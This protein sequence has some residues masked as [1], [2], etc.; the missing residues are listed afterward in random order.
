MSPPSAPHFS[1]LLKEC[2]DLLVR[3]PG[4][5]YL[6]ATIGPAGHSS[7]LLERA[8]NDAFLVGIDLDAQAL[9]LARQSLHSSPGRWWLVR[10]SF[11]QMDAILGGALGTFDAIL[12]DLGYSSAQLEDPLRGMSYSIDGPLDMRLSETVGPPASELINTLPTDDLAD[13]IRQFG[14]ERQ[15]GRVARAIDQARKRESIRT[16]GELANA[17]ATVAPARFRVKTLA[18]VFQAIRIRV[19]R[20][21]EALESALPA[22]V[23]LLA[24][25]GR[26]GVICFHSLEDRIVKHFMLRAVKDC[27]CPK[28]F[29]ACRC[30]HR[31][32]LR[33]I[34]RKPVRASEEEVRRNSRSRSATL[35]VAA[36]LVEKRAA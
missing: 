9:E 14:E 34:T 36:R 26:L 5:R 20:E 29:P 27:I 13:L 31:A 18:R 3:R 15:A 23:R 10:S 12:I 6:D 8:G 28:D 32:S 24:P 30:E 21:L 2:V 17:I 1:V 7:G 11:A 19:N 4:G 33:L 25:D 35:R 22:A 16:T